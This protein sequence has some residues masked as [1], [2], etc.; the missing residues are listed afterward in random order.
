M[1]S[2]VCGRMCYIWAELRYIL[3]MKSGK[4][5]KTGKTCRARP[6][7]TSFHTTILFLNRLEICDR[8]AFSSNFHTKCILLSLS[9]EKLY[10]CAWVFT[11]WWISRGVEGLRATTLAVKWSILLM[12][13]TIHTFL[14]DYSPL[15]VS[16][17]ILYCRVSIIKI[18][19]FLHVLYCVLVLVVF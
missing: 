14:F 4:H 10:M 9:H 16:S 13:C 17:P 5:S 3:R 8:I 18:S 1:F 7:N 12:Y 11:L 2:S 15:H 19:L 6:H